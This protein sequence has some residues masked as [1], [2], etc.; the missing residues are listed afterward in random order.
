MRR[1][2]RVRNICL[3][4]MAFVVALTLDKYFPARWLQ[5]V[6]GIGGLNFA[7]IALAYG[8]YAALQTR[9][10]DRLLQGVDVLARW[11]V[12]PQRWQAFL[13]MNDK[14]NTIKGNY[15]CSV[16]ARL[17]PNADGVDV[18]FGKKSL[19]IGDDFHALPARG[20]STLSW[21]FRLEGPPPCIEFFS[22]TSTKSGTTTVAFP[23]SHCRASRKCGGVRIRSLQGNDS[24]C[25]KVE[26]S[27]AAKCLALFGSV[28]RNIGCGGSGIPQV[29]AAR[30]A[31]KSWSC[32]GG[33]CGGLL[34]NVLVYR[35]RLTLAHATA[36][37]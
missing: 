7:F 26:L 8:L 32:C 21:P 1:P 9:R 33:S 35:V 13:E 15:Y 19:L 22:T 6:L 28:F 10:C 34:R 36:E 24:A 25:I 14:W 20:I 17:D 5:P 11:T 16:R 3:G 4:G 27:A 2:R 29:F 23:G 18:I 12:D 31:D 30:G 37:S